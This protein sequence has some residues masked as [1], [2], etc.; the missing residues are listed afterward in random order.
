M[1]T[2]TATTF[3]QTGFRSHYE[4]GNVVA[5]PG[6][7]VMMEGVDLTSDLHLNQKCRLQGGF[8]NLVPQPPDRA[9]W[10]RMDLPKDFH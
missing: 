1:Y 8:D 4:L 2:G 3:P 5:V 7:Y 9:N 6:C 10:R